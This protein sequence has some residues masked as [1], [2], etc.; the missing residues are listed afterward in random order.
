MIKVQLYPVAERLLGGGISIL[1]KLVYT[2]KY[3]L[4]TVTETVTAKV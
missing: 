2:H 1:G 3:C 4:N